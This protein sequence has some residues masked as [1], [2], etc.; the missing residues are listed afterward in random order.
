MVPELGGRPHVIP[1]GLDL[2][3][4]KP[5]DKLQARA[6]LGLAADNRYVLFAGNTWHKR[7]RF[8]LVEEAVAQLKARHADIEL[9]TIC[10]LPHDIIPAYM[11]ACDVFAMTSI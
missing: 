3:L 5:A 6:K 10:G 7:K 4:F 8:A 11:Q 9:V 2:D 1:C